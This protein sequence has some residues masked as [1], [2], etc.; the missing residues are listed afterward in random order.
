MVFRALLLRSSRAFL[1]SLAPA[2]LAQPTPPPGA[3]KLATDV[4]VSA[5]AEP[6]SAASLGVAATVIDSSE[7][8]ASKATTVLD[9]LRTVPGLDIVQS[10]GP[11]TVASL[12]LRGTSSTQ[13][14]VLVDGV[15]LNSPYFG[16]TDLSAL[17]VAN[18]ERVEVVRGPFSALYGSEA[19]GGVV[20]IFTRK[21]A[22]PGVNGN[23]SF[24]I[25]NADAKEGL[26]QLRFLEGVLSGTFGFRRTLS[27]GDQPNEFFSGTTLSGAL[28]A[29]LREGPSVGVSLRRET[30]RTGIPTD[31]A[32]PTPQR[33]TSAET[34]TLEV[35]FSLSLSKNLSLE[36]SARYVRD[37]PEYADPDSVFSSSSTEARRAGARLVFTSIL[38]GQRLAAGADWE[39]TLVSNESNFGVALEDASTR[40]FAL[41]AEDRVALAAERL[42]LTAG[43]RWDDHSAF[44]SAVSPRLSVAWRLAP[45][46]KARAAA[47]SAFRAPSTGELYYPFSG[48]PSLRPEKSNGY[49]LGL[50]KTLAGGVVAEVTGFW[51]DLKDLIDF[52][53]ATFTDQNVGRARTRGIE[54]V[55]RAPVGARSFVRASYMYLDAKDLDT[56]AFLLRRPRHRAS[57]TWGTTFVS[58]GSVSLTA[59]WVGAR[60]DRDAAD[61]TMLVEDPSYPRFDA[62]LTLPPLALSLAPFVRV[63]NLFGRDYAEASGFPAPGRRFLAGLEAAF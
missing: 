23:V 53:P 24:A 18:V 35:P 6:E 47:G 59:T 56:G 30:G 10:G 46:L 41:F 37:R 28:T 12:F 44:G 45:S 8:A 58:G 13:T 61:F 17:S 16:G 54:V 19:I 27:W 32:V 63:T 7:I 50:E 33:S 31:G 5:A 22:E 2:L 25:G 38:G 26:G 9:L 39:R 3:T 1:L 14:L 20:R 11:G 29:Q 15:P 34:T 49:E 48:N 52:D 62:A 43:V 60:P 4:V 51:N 57:A 55:L 21:G 42:V 40:T 36:A